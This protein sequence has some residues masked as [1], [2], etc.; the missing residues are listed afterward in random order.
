MC[1]RIKFYAVQ[2]WF[3]RRRVREPCA[4]THRRRHLDVRHRSYTHSRY[5]FIISSPRIFSLITTTRRRRAESDL[6]LPSSN[7]SKIHPERPC[8]RYLGKEGLT[9]QESLITPVLHQ[10]INLKRH[11]NLHHYFGRASSWEITKKDKESFCFSIENW[12]TPTGSLWRTAGSSKGVG[13][14]STLNCWQAK[15]IVSHV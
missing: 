6:P 10:V 1:V 11:Q 9:R 3:R 13:G 14:K 2:N 5:A 12:Q 4:V 15:P 7:T 8:R